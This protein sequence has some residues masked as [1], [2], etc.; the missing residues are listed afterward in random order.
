MKNIDIKNSYTLSLI[1]SGANS[2]IFK[3]LPKDPKD[4]KLDEA[5]YLMDYISKIKL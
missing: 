1:K 2:K 3:L 5:F 4:L